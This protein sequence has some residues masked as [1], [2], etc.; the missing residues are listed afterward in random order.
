MF[1]DVQQNGAFKQDEFKNTYRVLLLLIYYYYC[2]KLESILSFSVVKCNS[3][4]SFSYIEFSLISFNFF[5][6]C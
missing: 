4:S 5:S 2:E 3:C 6:L 1:N